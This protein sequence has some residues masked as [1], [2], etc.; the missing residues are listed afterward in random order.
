MA[1]AAERRWVKVAAIVITLALAGFIAFAI[2]SAVSPKPGSFAN[3]PPASSLGVGAKAP[4]FDVA[5]LDGDTRVR[6]A[7]AEQ[8]PVIVNFFASWCANC[9]AE[10]H[11]FGAVSNASSGVRFLGID[12]LDS[13]PV[14]ARKLL[15]VA[16]IHYQIGVDRS[17]SLANRYRIAALPVTFFVSR[18]GAI[19]G[20]LFGQA[21]SRELDY[22]VAKLG[23]K[24]G[25]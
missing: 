20:E 19:D 10:L 4:A 18:S 6:L 11:A 22:W 21:T 3:V 15:Q 25:R 12:S 9:V 24:V 14:T 23:G 2:D 1:G 7:A 16:E 5:S 13:A 8:S 17:G